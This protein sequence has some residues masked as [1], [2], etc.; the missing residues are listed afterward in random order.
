MM[1]Y[2]EIPEDDSW[3]QQRRNVFWE[4]SVKCNAPNAWVSLKFLH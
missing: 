3:I 2:E 4:E 1:F